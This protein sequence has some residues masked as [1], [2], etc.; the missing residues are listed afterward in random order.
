[1]IFK[2]LFVFYLFIALPLVALVL[3]GKYELF[4]SAEFTIGLAL[5]IFLYHPYISGLRLLHK[6]KIKTTE[7][8]RN[9]IPLWNSKYFTSLFFKK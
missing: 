7:F 4:S 5:Y 3:G 6:N 2:N 9:F 1:M 8:W